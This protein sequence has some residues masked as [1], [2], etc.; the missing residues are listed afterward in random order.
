MDFAFTEDQEALRELS[1]KILGDRITH[2]RLKQLEAEPEWFDRETWQELARAN[3]LGVAIDE[4]H[5]GMGFGFFELCILLSEVGRAVAPI[6]VYPTLLLGALPISR[7]GTD[8]QKAHYL[9]RIARGE[10][11]LSAAL[12]EPSSSDPRR[13]DTLASRVGGGFRLVGRKTC[14]PAAHLAE[15]ILVPA[16]LPDGRVG[17]FLVD[18]RAKGVSLE[19]QHST[20]HEPQFRIT[21]EDVA[22]S[23]SDVLGGS[24]A[25]VN[26]LHW[27]L[28]RAT[29][30]LCAIELGVCERALRITADYTAKREQFN[31]PIGAF[32]AVHQR[33]G[34]AFIDV[35]CI[36]WTTWR[37]VNSLAAEENASDDVSVAK[38]WAS[39]AGHRVV[40]AAQHLHGGIG[41]DVDYPIHRYY[42]WSRQI[43][44]TLGT[45]KEHV[46]RLG[47]GIAAAR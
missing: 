44:V 32:Q 12:L 26:A 34:D 30:G 24:P 43:E 6:P 39:E 1:R 42:L 27:L 33:A 19:R 20:S 45:G 31:Q 18:P 3:L 37:A 16:Q 7:F 14:A 29:T 9:P 13:I 28:E 21:L 47:E 15:R 40:Y 23:E 35:E 8:A 41:V 11:I 10:C 25:P 38:F 36:R 22:V 5:G 2:D 4:A 46:T 17:L